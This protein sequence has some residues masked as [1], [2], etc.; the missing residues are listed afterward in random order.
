MKIYLAGPL[1]STAER[2]F[3]DEIAARLRGEGFDRVG[4]RSRDLFERQCRFDGRSRLAHDCD[5]PVGCTAAAV[6]D[7]QGVLAELGEGHE[8]V[9]L[10]AAHH[11][12]VARDGD[13]LQAEA[14]EDPRVGVVVAG[15]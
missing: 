2:G 1:F 6:A 15:V 8:F 3:L 7:R 9:G 12:H 14:R 5:L 4:M 10:G 13:R 11:P